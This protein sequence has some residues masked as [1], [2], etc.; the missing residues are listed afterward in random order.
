MDL[1][2]KHTSICFETGS[3]APVPES[4]QWQRHICKAWMRALGLPLSDPPMCV[5]D[6]M[7]LTARL[8]AQQQTRDAEP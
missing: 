7:E 2:Q 1:K 4:V 8:V 5:L 6:L 3:D